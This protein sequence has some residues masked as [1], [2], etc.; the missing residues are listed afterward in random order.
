MLAF[1][2]RRLLLTL[3]LLLALPLGAYFLLFYA[4]PSWQDWHCHGSWEMCEQ[5][6]ERLSREYGLDRPKIVR[7]ADYLCG[8]LCVSNAR[9]GGI[10]TGDWGK[11][12]RD[13]RP[14]ADI[15]RQ[16]IPVSAQLGLAAFVVL[17]VVGVPLGVL[18][19]VKR[20]S[21]LG[22]AVAM[23]STVA[24]G[25]PIIVLGIMATMVVGAAD[26]PVPVEQT[27]LSS[28]KA[29]L[30]VVLVAVMAMPGVVVLTR[31]GV[32]EAL[33]QDHTRTARAKGLPEWRVMT[34]I[35]R[36]MLVPLVKELG[37]TVAALFFGLSI[38]EVLFSI[39][40]FA[41]EFVRSLQRQDYPLMAGVWI[42]GVTFV[43]LIDLTAKLGHAMLD[44]RVRRSPLVEVKLLS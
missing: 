28:A 22:H 34:Y 25:G 10:V 32:L 27:G 2:A 21:W 4:P 24:M 41:N 6:S 14:V 9:S 33:A 40:G 19:A 15:L 26:A 8:G 42:L 30:A 35:A 29:V 7:F 20:R 5:L 31:G 36:D 13:M 3:L 37:P 39:P 43:L 44:P 38:V 12:H 1:T 11:S 23:G 16:S 18:S 17:Y